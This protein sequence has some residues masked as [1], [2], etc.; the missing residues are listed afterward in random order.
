MYVCMYITEFSTNKCNLY[1]CVLNELFL[2]QNIE[3]VTVRRALKTPLKLNGR[4]D[5]V[6]SC[7]IIIELA[8][9]FCIRS[10]IADKCT[11]LGLIH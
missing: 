4:G 1:F 5:T 6:L 11:I 3:T 8:S 2:M 9:I 10:R 7:R